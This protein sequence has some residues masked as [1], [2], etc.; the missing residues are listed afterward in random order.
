[1]RVVLASTSPT[2]ARILRD[3]GVAFEIRDP[4][5]AEGAVKTEALAR[6]AGPREI[7]QT[8]AEL[9]ALAISGG[10]GGLVIGADQTLECEGELFDKAGDPGGARDQLMRLRGR[11]HQLY[12]AVAVAVDGRI[13][14]SATESAR[15]RIRAFSEAFLDRYLTQQT[16][17][18]LGL[19]GCYRLE[20]DG[21]QLFEAIDGDYFTILGLPLLGLLDLLRRRAVLT[22]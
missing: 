12:S 9:K 6:G 11:D 7:A 19:V 8:L 20:G 2:R 3:A 17:A 15:L 16:K 1:M 10:T 14:W 18:V 13:V 21:I 22:A 5:V 4:K